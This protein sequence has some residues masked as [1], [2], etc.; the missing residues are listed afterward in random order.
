MKSWFNVEPAIL[1]QTL[2]YNGSNNKYRVVLN[3]SEVIK[4]SKT[5]LSILIAFNRELNTD[6]ACVDIAR[7]FYGSTPKN[8]ISVSDSIIKTEILK[9]FGRPYYKKENRR[10]PKSKTQVSNNL[11]WINDRA[12]SF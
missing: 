8:L 2:S 11:Q 7:V 3:C 12:I 5:Y 1:Y 10:L 4:D 6:P 9:E